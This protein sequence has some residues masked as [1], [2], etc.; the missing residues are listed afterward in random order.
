M[1]SIYML[2]SIAALALKLTIFW[3]GRHSLASASAWLWLFFLGLFGMNLIEL[4][5][6]FYIKK[7]LE[8]VVWLS[9]YYICAELAFLSLLALALE[10]AKKLTKTLKSII[11][12]FFI[13]GTIPLLIPDAAL[14]GA[15]SIGYSVTRVAGPYYFVVQLCIIF[16]MLSAIIISINF[17]Q[18]KFSYSIRRKSQILLVACTPIFVSALLIMLIMQMNIAINASVILSLMINVS[19]LILIYTEH[20]ERMYRF[21]T[22]IP[23]TREYLFIKNLSQLITDPTIGLDAGRNL[24]EREMI[25]EALILVDGNKLKAAQMLGVSRQ[26][27]HR[28]LEKIDLE[29][30]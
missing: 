28:R 24:I 2:P 1:I 25:K 21:M 30:F 27:L 15:K 10:N 6:F 7:P 3:F 26:T 29:K 9:I 19:L 11:I 17:S 14:T 8:G 18:K 16:P 12:L 20:K 5:G 22:I 4:I 23:K 13:L